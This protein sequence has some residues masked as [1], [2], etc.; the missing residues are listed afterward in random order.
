MKN[1]GLKISVVILLIITLTMTNF[2]FL[3]SSLISYAVD[4][5]STNNKN[6]E[7]SA[8]FKNDQGEKVSSLDRTS[9]T[10][11]ISLYL[12]ISVKKEGF[13]NGQVE[14][15]NSN[16]NISSSES[17]YVSKIEGNKVYLNQINAGTTAEIELKAKTVENDNMDLN[18]LSAESDVTLTGIYRDSTEKDIEINAVKNVVLNLVEANTADSIENSVTVVTNKIIKISGEY[19]EKIKG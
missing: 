12:S 2:I 13:F 15:T 10:Q 5:I 1:K 19:Q 11:D 7:F 18:M 3:G 6:I 16:F 9:S 17:E 4:D 14:L 8:Y